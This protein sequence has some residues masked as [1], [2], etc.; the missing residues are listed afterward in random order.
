M[1]FG[2]LGPL[3]VEDH[4]WTRRTISGAR[5]RVLLAALLLRHGTPVS[6]DALVEAVWG[7]TPPAGA[8]GTLRSYITRL[9]QSL[10]SEAG[11]RIVARGAGYLIRV[12]ESELDVLEFEALCRRTAALCRSGAWAE[13]SAAAD[14]ALALWRGEPLSDVPSAALRT[15]FVPRLEE[16]RVQTIEDRNE[17]ELRLG[18]A[19]RLVPQLRDL[20]TR[21]PLRER[22]HAQLMEALAA[23]GRTAEAL[24]VYQAA[25]RILVEELGI[26]PGSELRQAQERILAG[27]ARPRPPDRT[28]PVPRQLPTGVRHFAGRVREIKILSSLLTQRPEPAGAVVISAIDGTAGI[29]KT[30]LAV[31]WAHQNVDRFPDG[32]LYANLR[33]FDPGGTPAETAIVARGFL[34]AL[35]VPAESIPSGL[36]AQLAL[37]RSRLAGRRMLVVLDNARDADQ[38]R[39]LLPGASGCLVLVT[40]RSR[41]T[42]LVAVDGAVPLSLDLFTEH[43]ARDLLAQRLGSERILRERDAAEALIGV[44]AGLPLAVNIVVA[45]A[46]VHPEQPLAALADELSAGSRLNALAI[47]DSAADLRAVFSSSYRVLADEAARV[48]RLLSLHPGSDVSLPAAASLVAL[49]RDRARDRLSELTA[50]NLLTEHTPGRYTYHDLLHAFALEQTLQ[51]DTED[52]RHE[53]VGRMLDHYLHTALAADR[54]VDPTRD[55]IAVPP[56]RPG[57]QPERPSDVDQAWRW[58]T[59][60]RQAL[61][62]AVAMALDR[63]FDEYA[64]RLPWALADLF[65]WQGHWEDQIN[66]QNIA[67]AAATRLE[68]RDVGAYAHRV[69]GRTHTRLASYQEAETHL[70]RAADHYERIGDALGRMHTY[71]GLAW[72]LDK[73][74]RVAEAVDCARRSLAIAEAAEHRAGEAYA[75]NSVGWLLTRLGDYTQALDC[76]RRALDLQ[77]AMGNVE[78]Q[79]NSLES[80]GYAYHHLGRHSEAI[81]S[82]EA[83]LPLLSQAGARFFEAD[84]LTHLGDA[85]LASGDR[86]AARDAWLRALAILEDL[87]HSDAAKVR[88]KLAA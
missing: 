58:C 26:E 12:E 44:C 24:E 73:Q 8:N 59:A 69:L 16:L 76:C 7:E 47:G 9:R 5:L 4:A 33:G 77:R 74:D 82:Y 17:A 79:G 49:G 57:V 35:E 36:D 29:G 61:L 25:R 67:L 27:A 84:T 39:P 6:V 88:A 10:E 50:A 72:V 71:R 22:F 18:R 68:N 87:R 46:A 3:V 11:E 70:R 78:G 13:V 31:H 2:L 54:L 52:A 64:W 85:H 15:R 65:H 62:A 32:Q 75:L 21:Y 41:L 45:H 42:G 28:G 34:D 1:R 14:R 55:P 43:E 60:E 63:G 20:V 80:L 86:E 51:H 37:Y 81:A 38:V 53:A 83:A 23:A 56:P 19:D 48:F 66:A 30:A 40:S